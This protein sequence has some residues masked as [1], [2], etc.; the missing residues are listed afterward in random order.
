MHEMKSSLS[1][2][3]VDNNTIESR[4]KGDRKPLSDRFDFVELPESSTS[5]SA[6]DVQLAADHSEGRTNSNWWTNMCGLLLIGM[7]A[8]FAISSF[9]SNNKIDSAANLNLATGAGAVSGNEG[10]NLDRLSQSPLVQSDLAEN[11]G[12]KLAKLNIE[13][14]QVG[15]R[16]PAQNPLEEEIENESIDPKTWR[17][18]RLKMNRGNGPRCRS[19]CFVPKL[20]FV[21]C[22]Y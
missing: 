14:I 3:K 16:V 21:N 2:T 6:S 11:S 12:W 5:R 19:H 15:M 17:K 22:W 13:D 20:G 4:S 8:C 9:T 10:S 18:V 7:F 1:E